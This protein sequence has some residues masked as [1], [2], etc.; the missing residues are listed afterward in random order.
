MRVISKIWME[1]TES[2][3]IKKLM[4]ESVSIVKGA[5]RLHAKDKQVELVGFFQTPNY[6]EKDND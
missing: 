1:P 6:G 3:K 2:K 5:T 4:V